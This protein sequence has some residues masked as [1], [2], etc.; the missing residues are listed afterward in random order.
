[1]VAQP[2]QQHDGDAAH[3]AGGPGDHDRAVCR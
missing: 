1:V 3:P 2:G